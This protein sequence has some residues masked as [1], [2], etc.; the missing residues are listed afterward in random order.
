MKYVKKTSFKRLSDLSYV[1]NNLPCIEKKKTIKMYD[2]VYH[3]LLI[4][5][6]FK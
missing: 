6:Y 5:G 4:S 1:L 2:S 3:S